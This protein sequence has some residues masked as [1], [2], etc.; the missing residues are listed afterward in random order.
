M[1][2]TITLFVFLLLGN[3]LLNAQI[4]VTSDDL[5]GAG[6]IF[7]QINDSLPGN[8]ITPGEPGTNMEWDF[9]SINIH[10]RDTINFMDP[11]NTPYANMFPE[12][13]KC[14]EMGEDVPY[15]Y[16]VASPDSVYMVGAVVDT[17]AF[18]DEMI[19]EFDPVQLIMLSPT[20]YGTNFESIYAF[21]TTMYFGQTITL[22]GIPYPVFVDSLKFKNH[23]N[24]NSE[25]DSWGLLTTPYG[26][27]ET[28]REKRTE[29]AHDSLFAK[30]MDIGDTWIDVTSWLGDNVCTTLSYSWLNSDVG[31]TIFELDVDPESGNTLRA[32]CLEV[33]GNAGIQQNVDVMTESEVYPVPANEVIY[34]DMEAT[35]RGI[36]SIYN[37][38]G[39]LVAKKTVE[40]FPATVNINKLKSSLYF[41]TITKD[42]QVIT[43]G[44]FSIAR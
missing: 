33:E 17:S 6:S 8:N 11:A 37:L 43:N 24:T 5:P 42:G 21:E 44:K 16:I 15:S 1:K 40:S 18:R 20:S 22:P 32:R 35:D 14:V 39:T 31:Y 29:I 26:N 36:I 12:A 10:Y 34:I 38:T 3:F 25:I 9:S 28:L 41:Y 19:I 23:T 4:T 2:K 30:S 7:P 13:N 27:F